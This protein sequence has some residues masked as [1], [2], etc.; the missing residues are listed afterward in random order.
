MKKILEFLSQQKV[1]MVAGVMALLGFLLMY[2]GYYVLYMNSVYII[3]WIL[4]GAVIGYGFLVFFMPQF[5]GWIVALYKL[6]FKKK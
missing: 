3:G 6:I 1:L 2:L 4:F 5:I